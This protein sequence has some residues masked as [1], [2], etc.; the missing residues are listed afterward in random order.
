MPGSPGGEQGQGSPAEPPREGAP[1][2]GRAVAEESAAAEPMDE[3]TPAVAAPADAEAVPPADPNEPKPM[4]PIMLM[5][6]KA[7]VPDAWTAAAWSIVH[8]IGNTVECWFMGLP[9]MEACIGV[10]PGSNAEVEGMRREFLGLLKDRVTTY[11]ADRNAYPTQERF[12]KAM[13]DQVKLLCREF[14]DTHGGHQIPQIE[15]RHYR[16]VTGKT[17]DNFPDRR[18]DVVA[19]AEQ[20]LKWSSVYKDHARLYICF[21]KLP[22]MVVTIGTRPPTENAIEEYKTRFFRELTATLDAKHSKS[23]Y[24]LQMDYVKAMWETTQAFAE[25]FRIRNGDVPAH[26]RAELVSSPEEAVKWSVVQQRVNYLR[27]NFMRLSGPNGEMTAP[28]FQGTLPP[29]QED[30]DDLKNAFMAEVSLRLIEQ[31]PRANYDGQEQFITAMWETSK[32]L[33]ERYQFWFGGVALSE[34][35]PGG[36][37]NLAARVES[38]ACTDEAVKWS[39]VYAAGCSMWVR[40][41]GIYSMRVSICPRPDTLAVFR[42]RRKSFLRLLRS[43]IKERNRRESYDSQHEYVKA[44]WDTC[45]EVADAFWLAGTDAPEDKRSELVTS[46]EQ[47]LEWS[48]VAKSRDHPVEGGEGRPSLVLRFIRLPTMVVPIAQA[49]ETDSEVAEMRATFFSE[50]RPRLAPHRRSDFASQAEFI[51]T[52]WQ[53]AQDFAKE[54]QARP[55]RGL[56]ALAGASRVSGEGSNRHYH[57]HPGVRV[58]VVADAEQA[59][60]W[61]LVYEENGEMKVWFMRL[62]NMVASLGP[63]TGDREEAAEKRETFLAELKEVLR[64]AHPV[65]KYSSKQDFVNA[66][67]ESTEEFAEMFILKRHGPAAVRAAAASSGSKVGIVESPQQAVE[68]SRVGRTGGGRLCF[69][70]MKLSGKSVVIGNTPD[71]KEGEE[72]LKEEFVAGLT[73]HLVKRHT[74]DKYVTQRSFVNAMWESCKEYAEDFTERRVARKWVPDVLNVPPHRRIDVVQ[75]AEQAVD[76]S[77]VCKNGAG[78]LALRFMKMS[79]MLVSIGPRPDTEEATDKLKAKYLSELKHRLSTDHPRDKYSSQRHFVNAMWTGAQC[80]SEEFR[81]R[82]QASAEFEA[83]AEAED[84]LPG[85]AREAVG[86]ADASDGPSESW[87]FESGKSDSGS[88]TNEASPP[89]A[90][91]RRG[92]KRAGESPTASAGKRP[93]RKA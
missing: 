70:F 33:A 26:R 46:P 22:S 81:V 80:F 28:L 66:M 82:A 10:F 56:V 87:D 14:K 47:A 40:F 51:E 59:V 9:S 73:E 60:D 72:Q 63:T 16:S 55:Q 27:F 90:S 37:A 6:R 2:A 39:P 45:Q 12:V 77:S 4:K 76:W 30:V 49:P 69:Y 15:H 42:L 23:D 13:W 74:R 53:T 88:D 31:H 18:V 79:N 19:N 78:E 17:I 38:V 85:P 44:M 61:S 41:L 75:S 89:K 62:H 93:R 64:K 36:Y 7:E 58:S 65:A 35:A 86:A 50:L 21:M 68:W 71:S 24:D 54:F 11:C 5:R 8:A 34:P 57:V 92:G 67:W 48:S 91:G 32:K 43:T 52:L 1:A 20:A 84:A 29:L 25:E 83:R 3:D